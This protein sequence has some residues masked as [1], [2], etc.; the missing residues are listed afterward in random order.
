MSPCADGG[1]CDDLANCSIIDL[2]DVLEPSPNPCNP[3]T[4]LTC[5]GD[6]TFK[7]FLPPSAMI[8]SAGGQSASPGQ[9]LNLSMPTVFHDNVSMSS[10]SS[11]TIPKS[12][13]YGLV[14]NA[15]IKFNAAGFARLDIRLDGAGGPDDTRSVADG[16]LTGFGY[17]VLH[18]VQTLPLN[19]GQV[20]TVRFE[21]DTPASANVLLCSLSVYWISGS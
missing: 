5:K 16:N 2:G 21:N 9:K 13:F 12:G 10:S 17:Q 3:G 1:T 15:N 14:S 19:Q 18:A 8:L 4:F 6:G 7:W 11:I 20:L